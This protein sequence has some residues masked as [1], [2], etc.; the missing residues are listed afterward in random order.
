MKTTTWNQLSDA[1]ARNPDLAQRLLAD[2]D[3]EAEALGLR[4]SADE[5][6]AIRAFDGAVPT[7]EDII[8]I[9]ERQVDLVLVPNH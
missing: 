4:L 2:P 8:Q 3:G 6:A 9:A 5:I 1:V 7:M